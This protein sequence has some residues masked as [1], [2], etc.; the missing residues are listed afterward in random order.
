MTSTRRLDTLASIGGVLAILA[1]VISIA[2]NAHLMRTVSETQDG[3]SERLLKCMPTPDMRADLQ[4]PDVPSTAANGSTPQNALSKYRAAA[5]KYPTSARL[6]F[7]LGLAAAEPE[8]SNAFRRA[9]QLDP[10]NALPLY[11]L[12]RKAS[13]TGH[14]DEAVTLLTQAN[15]CAGLDWYL[16]PYE[17]CKGNGTSEMELES[18]N[19]SVSTH[20]A[21][22]TRGLAHE[23]TEH[24]LQLHS[25]GKTQDGLAILGQVREMGWKLMHQGQT[26][27]MDVLVGT[28]II[29]SA[30][31]PERQIYTATGNKAGLARIER[32]EEEFI[33]LKAGGRAYLD[34]AMLDLV[35]TVA[36]FA[37]L[38]LPLSAA[39]AVS[40]FIT[41]VSMV[42]GSL[43]AR[44]SKGTPASE[45]H[46][47]AT[48][49]A[50]AAARLARLYALVIVVVA[51]ITT[52]LAS[53]SFSSADALAR[54][55]VGMALGAVSSALVVLCVM[56]WANIAYKRAF[57]EAAES[58]GDIAS[59]PWK[60][61][62]IADK[63]ER[64][65]R[66]TGVTGG[67]TITL[68][69]WGVVLSVYMKTTM[70]SYPWQMDRA[71]AGLCQQ[72]QQYMHDLVA[73]KIDVP[74]KYIKQ[75]QSEETVKAKRRP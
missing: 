46:D 66:L 50:F 25:A 20:C 10:G 52:A 11:A 70:D 56:V 29:R 34:Q 24:A 60:G 31:K 7:H 64:Q 32:D 14:W 69:I 9:V 53:L 1:I 5:R 61:Y 38:S 2:C 17:A 4:L 23:L 18:K 75:V 43:L 68:A 67:V 21:T 62:T 51:A 33:R 42:W 49:R 41:I 28:A 44:R 26:S 59:R 55:S 39:G 37:A 54:D 19:A 71:T 72:E 22:I 15:R 63:R 73:G 36:H 45:L 35:R 13:A 6:Q 57:Q 58:D 3:A 74:A 65:R 12:A 8:S 40:A 30:E 16:F 48:D 47:M 27:V